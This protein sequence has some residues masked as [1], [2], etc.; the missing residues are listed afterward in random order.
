MHVVGVTSSQSASFGIEAGALAGFWL[1][2]AAFVAWTLP[3]SPS[4]AY[5]PFTCIF[6]RLGLSVRSATSQRTTIGINVNLQG[7]TL[8]MGS[9]AFA[10]PKSRRRT[11]SGGHYSDPSA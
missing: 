11:A 4:L 2:L 3:A 7:N 9:Q 10:L 6:V 5:L 8:S 1:A